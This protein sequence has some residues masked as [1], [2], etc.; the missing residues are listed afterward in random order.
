MS[1]FASHTLFRPRTLSALTV[2]ALATAALLASPAI[3]T[4]AQPPTDAPQMKVYYSYHEL[5]TD[6]GS[7]AL[8]QRI[9][10]AAEEVCPAYSRDLT[11]LAASKECQ[12]EAVAQAI[13]QIGSARLAAVHSQ[14]LARRG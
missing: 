1:R 10:R 8:Y 3:A 9:T 13:N 6:Q 12:R 4:A 11:A 2:G 7:R 14:K 5:A